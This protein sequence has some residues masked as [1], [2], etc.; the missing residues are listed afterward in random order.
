MTQIS[1]IENPG[2][3]TQEVFESLEKNLGMVPNIFKALANSPAALDAYLAFNQALSAGKLCPMLKE[4]IA[5]TVAGVNSCNYC[6]SAHTALGLGLSIEKDE[7]KKNIEAKSDC[8]KTEAALQFAKA[9]VVKH[10]RDLDSEFK[11]VEEAGFSHGE[12]VEV[13]AVVSVNIFTN[14]F[15]HIAGTEVDFPLVQVQAA[16]V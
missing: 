15:N 16:K 1:L 4:K 6:A 3:K 14:Y 12:I 2:G 9:I 8:E 11:A 7:L 13:I 5:L 10:G